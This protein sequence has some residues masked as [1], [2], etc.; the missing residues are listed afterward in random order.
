MATEKSRRY[1][2]PGTDK[3][4]Q[5]LLKEEVEQEILRSRN[6][7]IIS[8]IKKNCLNS[9]R[10]QLLYLFTRRVIKQTVI[11]IMAHYCYQQRTQFYPTFF[12]Q[13]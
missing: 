10:S 13:G 5:N 12:C 3:F 1:T 4:Q 6:L 2:S 7:L 11:L 9:G 8:G